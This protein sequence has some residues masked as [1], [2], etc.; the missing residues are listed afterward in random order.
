[1]RN[2]G[3]DESVHLPHLLL[4]LR[5]LGDW[6]K[7]FLHRW[8][9]LREWFC[10]K[11]SKLKDIELTSSVLNPNLQDHPLFS[12]TILRYHHHHHIRLIQLITNITSCILYTLYLLHYNIYFQLCVSSPSL[13]CQALLSLPL[14]RGKNKGHLPKNN[15][16][17]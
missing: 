14:T 1:M 15:L 5:G 7:I 3:A 16:R 11:N 6:G 2:P 12:S 9:E 17:L 10:K 8:N 13:L 4:L